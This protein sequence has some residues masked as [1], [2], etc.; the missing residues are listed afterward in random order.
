MSP[1]LEILL[2]IYVLIAVVVVILL[3]RIWR[4]SYEKDTHLKDQ[5]RSHIAP[6]CPHDDW[7]ITERKNFWDSSGSVSHSWG[8]TRCN[9]CGKEGGWNNR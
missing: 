1:E 7:D 8:T 6:D 3:W 2:P 4:K 5:G 9:I